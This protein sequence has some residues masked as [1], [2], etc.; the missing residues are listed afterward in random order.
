MKKIIFIALLMLSQPALA[1]WV[2]DQRSSIINFTTT[3]NSS[4]TEVQT[5]NKITGNINSKRAVLSVDLNSVDTGIAIRDTRLRELFFDV[6][7]FPVARVRLNVNKARLDKLKQGQR[8]V[9]QLDAVIDLHGL[10]KTIPVK[11][12]IVA[13]AK[14]KVLV[15]TKE[16]LIVDLKDFNLLAGSEAL[17]AIAK[18]TSIN[19][20]VPVTFNL[21]FTKK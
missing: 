5:F 14:G 19:T 8:K 17:R 11:V 4:K 10:Q 9:L 12:Q 15:T 13:F 16:P 7:D 2:L 21:F 3:K 20:A 1:E 6:M 18:L